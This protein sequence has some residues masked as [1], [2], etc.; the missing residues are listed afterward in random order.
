MDEN[1]IIQ[2]RINDI[3]PNRFQPRIKFNDQAINELANS[4][5][6]FGML[7]PIIVR[8][9]G[10]KYEIVAGERRYKASTIA[11][12]ETIPAIVRDLDD[13]NSAEVALI[14]NVQRRDLT[15]IEEA[16]SYKKILDMGYLNQEE[17]A[18]RLSKTQSA[19]SNKL[20]LL[21]LDEEVQE[22]LLDNKIS[23]RHAR[24][25]LK[26]EDY[27]MQRVLLNKIIDERLTVR[28]TDQEI[29]EL[30]GYANEKEGGTIMKDEETKEIF[31]VPS[32]SIV[33]DIE[34]FDD[35]IEVNETSA[36]PPGYLDVDEIEK[37]AEQINVEKPLADMDL[38]LQS[39]NNDEEEKIEQEVIEG[40]Y[41]DFIAS[42]NDDIDE[43]ITNLNNEQE[44]L[45]FNY[46]D[47]LSNKE[48][49][50]DYNFNLD[51]EKE[52][53]KT[54]VKDDDDDSFRV[55]LDNY[56]FDNTDYTQF[57]VLPKEETKKTFSDLIQDIRIYSKEIE[58]YG[59]YID[60]DEVDFGDYY[61]V[62]FKISKNGN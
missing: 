55:N 53:N 16:V 62:T 61:E 22:A 41:F 57:D 45:S 19:I 29:E 36:L 44:V 6:K 59:Y 1:E 11:G 5:K 18:E 26:L 14:E 40:K 46:D 23:E 27:A 15:P 21:N 35:F 2:I 37:T 31:N 47:D 25:L 54:D 3:L 43:Q 42:V 56:T 20:R 52:E 51:E 8:R 17:L 24:S 28:K 50:P 38:L 60:V 10:D 48:V 7:Q 9:I 13:Q 12:L 4:I 39:D 30:L 34:I 32:V 33:D 58:N 49:L